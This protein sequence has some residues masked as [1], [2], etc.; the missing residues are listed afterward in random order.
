MK[1]NLLFFFFVMSSIICLPAQSIDYNKM[2]IW[3]EIC[4]CSRNNSFHPS[5]ITN[6]D[7]NWQLLLAMKNGL[8]LKELDSLQIPYKQSQLLLLR[9]QRLLSRND[10]IYKTSI[11]ILADDQTIS[12]RKQSLA[13]AN[14]MY[15][16]VEKECEELVAYLTNQQQ[17]TNAFSILFSYILDGLIWEKFEKEGLIEKRDGTYIWSGNYWFIT[18]K[19]PFQCGSNS[20]SE[21]KYVFTFNWSDLADKLMDDFYGADF[22]LLMER[23]KKEGK[24]TNKEFIDEF[25]NF[26]F[27]DNKT[28]LTVPIIA[29]SDKNELYVLS[30]KIIDK[31]LPAFLKSTNIE[32]IQKNYAFKNGSETIVVFYHEVMWDLLNL[33]VE[34]QVVQMPIIFKSPDKATQ[35][36]IANLCFI[37]I[38]E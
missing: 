13:V 14:S 32:S 5:T 24:I 10:D 33:L 38:K 29:E 26:G 22:D 7:N 34:K 23:L 28:N 9:S 12:L 21:G 16:E 36:D 6:A 8:T 27:F 20:Y 4:F 35:K 17:S 1:R 30:N 25:S 15:P 2:D 19:R 18:P 11:P 37:T 31:L 3:E